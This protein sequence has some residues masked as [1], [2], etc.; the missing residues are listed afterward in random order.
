RLGSQRAGREQADPF[1]LEH[2]SLLGKEVAAAGSLVA[3]VAETIRSLSRGRCRHLQAE[4]VDRL[5][6]L[7]DLFA[8]RCGSP[9]QVSEDLLRFSIRDVE[10][11]SDQRSRECVGNRSGNLAVAVGDREL[12]D[13]R[14]PERRDRYML[15]REGAWIAALYARLAQSTLR[16]RRARDDRLCGIGDDAGLLPSSRIRRVE[17]QASGG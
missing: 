8:E 2:P 9:V 3:L 17:H 13:A 16:Q 1:G 11:R 7:R 15:P 6:S 14:G 12:Q 5:V 4:R 10:T